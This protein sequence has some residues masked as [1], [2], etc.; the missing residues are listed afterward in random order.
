MG[1]RFIKKYSKEDVEKQLEDENLKWVE[2][3]FINMSSKI[4]VEDK[5]NKEFYEILGDADVN[6][7]LNGGIEQSQDYPQ[8]PFDYSKDDI[9]FTF[10]IDFDREK[11]QCE[12]IDK[13]DNSI[14]YIHKKTTE[15][16]YKDDDLVYSQ[17]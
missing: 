17:N 10:F 1:N 3:T 6:M 14:L 7:I 2:G 4:L 9:N 8:L 16:K 15:L 5:E 12:L 11:F 13:E